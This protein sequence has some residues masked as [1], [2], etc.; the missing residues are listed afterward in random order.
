MLTLVVAAALV[1][2]YFYE[3]LNIK[4][5]TLE[6]QVD[7]LNFENRGYSEIEDRLLTYERSLKKIQGEVNRVWQLAS[8]E[9]PAVLAAIEQQIIAQKGRL[10]E[11]QES[12]AGLDEKTEVYDRA[13]RTIQS[14]Q[15]SIVSLEGNYEH[16]TK[17]FD[18]VNKQGRLLDAR[19]DRAERA[20]DAI[21]KDRQRRARQLITIEK[22]L[23]E[24]G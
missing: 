24:S 7:T 20:I 21:D 14:V 18:K 12:L 22:R 11:L 3:R 23:N 1:A 4:L 2:A 17:N 10:D 5:T 8:K 13:Q 19:I 6:T 9:Q 15:A 16:T